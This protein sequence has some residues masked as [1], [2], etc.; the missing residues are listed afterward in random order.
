MVITCAIGEEEDDGGL[1]ALH[2]WCASRE[3]RPIR[4]GVLDDAPAVCNSKG[5]QAL[6]LACAANYF[7]EDALITAFPTFPWVW[8]GE[9][10]L[11]IHPEQ[12][13]EVRIV[14]GDGRQSDIGPEP[15]VAISHRPGSCTDR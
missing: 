2:H 11:V 6:V 4:F 7:D 13:G 15:N 1:P 8:P 12:E 10:T 5:M 3:P 9:A 14:R